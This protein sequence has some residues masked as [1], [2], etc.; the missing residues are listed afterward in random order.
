MFGFIKKNTDKQKKPEKTK[1]DDS[2][3]IFAGMK[4]TTKKG[5]ENSKNENSKE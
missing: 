1:I 4:V 3:D 2:F 5:E